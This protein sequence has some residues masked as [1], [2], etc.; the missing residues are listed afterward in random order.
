M[1]I[2]FT[3][4]KLTDLDDLK[5]VLSQLSDALT[6]KNINSLVSN[7][8][9]SKD[10]F[11]KKDEIL[12][13]EANAKKLAAKAERDL[14][15]ADAKL[16]DLTIAKTKLDNDVLELKVAKSKLEQDSAELLNLKNEL[17]KSQAALA[18]ELFTAK[19]SRAKYEALVADQ[20]LKNAELDARLQ[21]VKIKLNKLQEI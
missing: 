21:D 10:L 19:E 18:A 3:P 4:D 8:E 1:A 13:A 2:Q 17:T 7:L 12:A 15:N 14:A 5:S 16:A 9:D 6:A 11:D 20:A